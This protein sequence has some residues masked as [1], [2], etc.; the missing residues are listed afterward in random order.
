MSVDV[1]SAIQGVVQAGLVAVVQYD[2]SGTVAAGN[3]ISQSP[4]AGTVVA[5][6]SSVVL[7][8]SR[9]AK[10]AVGVVTVPNVVG[11]TATAAQTALA[12]VG[13]SLGKY[14]WQVNAAAQNTVVAQSVTSGSMVAPGTIVQ[15]T[16]SAG[17]ARV[18]STVSVP[19]VS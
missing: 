8:V 7:V 11:L 13:L 5:V 3:V 17:P 1:A 9:G 19:T 10:N 4:A 6:N 2:E 12:A 16:L 15:L 18:P 14:I